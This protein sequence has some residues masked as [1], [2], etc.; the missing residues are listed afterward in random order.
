MALTDA[1]SNA[2]KQLGLGADIWFEKDKQRSTKY[3][4]QQEIKEINDAEI[5]AA[6]DDYLA[7][8]DKA[9][10]YYKQKYNVKFIAL[11]KGE[12]MTEIYNELKKN[13]RI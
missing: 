1:L 12:Q 11:L 9:Q 6:V 3:D 8:N 10:E 5:L 4:L 2:T 13:K 7:N